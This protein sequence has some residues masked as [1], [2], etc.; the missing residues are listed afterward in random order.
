MNLK[1]LLLT[2]LGIILLGQTAQSQTVQDY[3]EEHT[4]HARELMKE[5]DVP[6]SVILAVAIH[7]SA[8]GK[9]KVARHLNN[10][11]G[12]KGS[13]SNTDISSSYR[14]Y[15]NADE[16]YDNFVEVLQNT[17]S[18]NKLFDKY[19]QYDYAGWARGIQRG[20]YA[21]SRTWAKQVIAIIDKYELYQYDDRPADYVE[22]VKV[23]PDALK[24][25]YS[26][27][28][29]HQ[30][31]HRTAA[32]TYTVRKGDNLNRLAESHGTSATALMRKNGL[33][34]SALQPGQKIRF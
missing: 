9:S 27:S 24:K 4:D 17:S 7:E 30:R 2:W 20:G 28:R 5:Y 15:E 3:V 13:N 31:H 8:A 6:A 16:S 33:K 18:F 22:P 25:T 1:T 14:D 23:V 10:H 19:D 29:S 32:R 34:R 26:R 21:A 12:I 11:F